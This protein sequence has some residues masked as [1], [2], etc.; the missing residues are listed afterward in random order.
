MRPWL[1]PRTSDSGSS[2]ERER[3]SEGEGR[4]QGL[5]EGDIRVDRLSKGLFAE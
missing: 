1:H 2:W 4:A 3:G 5:L